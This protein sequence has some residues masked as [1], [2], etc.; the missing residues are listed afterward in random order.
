M[1]ELTASEFTGERAKE[2]EAARLLSRALE[3][4]V[5]VGLDEHGELLSSRQFAQFIEKQRDAANNLFFV[6]GGDEGLHGSI[7][8]KAK[9]TLSLSKM[10]LPHRLARLVLAEQVYR[11][12][13]IIAREPYHK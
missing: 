13:S 5:L 6:I 9:L 10:T 1:L 4:D 8:K 7:L 2:D 11:A 3:R 12:F